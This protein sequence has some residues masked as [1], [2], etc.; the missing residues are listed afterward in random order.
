M[1]TIS[2]ETLVY[3]IEKAR[4]YDE[5]VPV[6]ADDD[7]SNDSDDRE[8]GIL[9]DTEDNPTEQELRELIDGLN[10]D[11]QEELLALMYLGR[12]DFDRAGWADAM[13]QARDVVDAHV[14]DYLMGTPMLGDYLEEGA[15]ALDISLADIEEDLP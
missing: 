6:D 13:R 7:G 11:E 2:L 5:E 3:I 1:L 15:A 14:A 8:V 9:Q 4:E 12:G 10:V